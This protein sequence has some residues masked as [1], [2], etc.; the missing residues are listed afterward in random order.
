MARP[1]VRVLVAAMVV[2][3]PLLAMAS[4]C[5]SS[6]SSKGFGLALQG[7]KLLDTAKE[8]RAANLQALAIPRELEKEPLAPFVVEGLMNLRGQLVTALDMRR[9]LGLPPREAGLSP[10]NIVVRSADGAV[11]L[12][13]DEIGDVVEPPAESYEATPETMRAEEKEIIECVCKLE[14][15][16]LLV[17]DVDRLLRPPLASHLDMRSDAA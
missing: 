4:G 16:L 14:G 7:H 3:V 11:S 9:K 12:L 8:M 13:A 2:S 15:K 5:A 17:L 1:N 10:M 6:P